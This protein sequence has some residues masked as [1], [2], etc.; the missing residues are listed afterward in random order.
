MIYSHSEYMSIQFELLVD[1]L[2]NKNWH[3]FLL[4]CFFRLLADVMFKPLA[5]I[6]KTFKVMLID[7]IIAQTGTAITCILHFVVVARNNSCIWY[8]E[9]SLVGAVFGLILKRHP[10]PS[11]IYGRR[12]SGTESAKSALWLGTLTSTYWDKQNAYHTV[13]LW[14]MDNDETIYLH[15][16]HQQS[17]PTGTSRHHDHMNQ[18][19]NPKGKERQQQ[20]SCNIHDTSWNR[21]WIENKREENMVETGYTNKITVF[22]LWPRSNNFMFTEEMKIPTL[23]QRTGNSWLSCYNN[24]IVMIIFI[25]IHKLTYWI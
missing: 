18:T 6:Y 21:L 5:N 1:N 4:S 25:I 3:F 14:V 2:R 8:M 24:Y 19:I 7:V 13:P 11:N 10:W 23:N 17:S 16:Q 9:N 20:C 22:E 12:R 15:L